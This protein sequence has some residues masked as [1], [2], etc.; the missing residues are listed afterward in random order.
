MR[1]LAVAA[2]GGI[3][4]A[5]C[6]SSETTTQTAEPKKL[7][8]S[9]QWVIDQ[10]IAR[11][12]GEA[13]QDYSLEFDFRGRHYTVQEHADQYTY[14]REWTTDT[15]GTMRDV[16]TNAGFIRREDGERVTLSAE[17]SAKY[18]NSVNSVAYFV[19]LPQ[20]LNDPAVF[21]RY[22]GQ[23][24][25]KGDTY[26]KVRVTFS[27]EGGGTDHDDV[28]YYWVHTQHHTVDYLAYYYHTDGG[29]SRFREAINPRELSGM[30]IL[31]YVNYT[32]T[33]DSVAV[34]DYDRA[35]D[36]GRVK[37]LSRIINENAQVALGSDSP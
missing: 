2:L 19:R 25:I 6:Q 29:G 11:H 14:V 3:L 1:Y 36:E 31:D 21:K 16:L 27:E 4:F 5:A 22:A 28:F 17:D 26:H 12:G 35:F 20:G 23:V 33:G 34:A 9:A 7:T 18:A 32:Y 15:T 24:A 10:A 30:L 13:Y 37:E 8:D